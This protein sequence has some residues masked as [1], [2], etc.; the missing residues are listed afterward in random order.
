MEYK[1]FDIDYIERT[2]KIIEQYEILKHQININ[3]RFEVTL[4]T[5]SLLALIVF[6]KEKFYSVI[7]TDRIFTDLKKEMGIP[8]SFISEKYKTIRELI[9]DLRHSIAHLNFDFESDHNTNEINKIIFRDDSTETNPIIAEF[10]PS[11]LA[12]FIR[13]YSSWQ[14]KNIREYKKIKNN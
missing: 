1:D 4:L 2:V 9:I 5:N 3:E 13:Y 6:P 11:E 7:P 10:I 8:N 12:N 14:I